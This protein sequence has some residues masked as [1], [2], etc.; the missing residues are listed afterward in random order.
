[1]VN[2]NQKLK[3]L[4]SLKD[5]KITLSEAFPKTSTMW[6]MQKDYTVKSTDTGDVISK[7][8]LEKRKQYENPIVM[9][10]DSKML[11]WA[12][13]PPL[14][15][16]ALKHLKIER[17]NNTWLTVVSTGLCENTET[18]EVISRE[19]FDKKYGQSNDITLCNLKNQS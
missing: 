15:P 1:M 6:V 10:P 5:G 8:E 11:I 14:H 4:N 13:V 9:V 16:I 3:L 7:A 17:S 2:R 19:A 18:G 12:C